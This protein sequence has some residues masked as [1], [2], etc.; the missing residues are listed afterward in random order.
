M[1]NKKTVKSFKSFVYKETR[2]KRQGTRALSVQ[3]AGVRGAGL[4][5]GAL[6]HYKPEF[7][8]RFWLLPKYLM[9]ILSASFPKLTLNLFS[10]ALPLTFTC[11]VVGGIDLVTLSTVTVTSSR[12]GMTA[13]LTGSCS[14]RIL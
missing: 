7:L 5:P 12:R 1:F 13:E 6:M 9:L 2:D 10:S 14:A 3:T 4:I 11:P 8:R